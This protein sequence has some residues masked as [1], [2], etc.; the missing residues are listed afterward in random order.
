MH[1]KFQQSRANLIKML[2]ANGA[3]PNVEWEGGTAIHAVLT[4]S[5]LEPDLEEPEVLCALMDAK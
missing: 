1:F 3:D 2:L 5:L 4:P